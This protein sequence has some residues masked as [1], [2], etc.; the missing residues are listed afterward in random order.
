VLVLYTGSQHSLSHWDV[1]PKR[2]QIGSGMEPSNKR[3]L[4]WKKNA[5]CENVVTAYFDPNKHSQITVDASSSGLAAILAQTDDKSG[6]MRPIIYC[7]RS[8]SDVET[9]YSQTEL[10]ALSCVWAV[11]R[12]HQYVYGAPMFD[13]ITD[14]KAL[15]VIYGN[16]KAKLP[17]CIERWG[18]RLAPYQFRVI[19]KSGKDNPADYLS[20]HSLTSD[21]EN[22]RCEKIAEEYINLVINSAV[23]L[24]MTL[25]DIRSASKAD[26]TLTQLAKQIL[27]GK[28][29]CKNNEQLRPFKQV[30][31]ELSTS[32]GI[33][34]RQC[35]L[36]IPTVLQERAV[37]LAHEGHQGIVKTK[38]LLRTKCW[39][40]WI[41][42]MTEN[43]VKHCLACQANTPEKHFEQLLLLLLLLFIIVVV[44]YCDNQTIQFS[45]NINIINNMCPCDKLD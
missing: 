21:N 37:S 12:L 6:E 19:H 16:A 23:R 11:E 33:I 43:M 1:W 32:D 8:L 3:F 25:D 30:F 2:K 38:T 31:S 5:L 18:L 28:L 27:A 40:P 14:H 13:L 35:R 22:D 44:Y 20:R 24:A 26:P 4:T 9:R 10:E 42:E 15:E 34:L 7:S 45:T 39:F 41:D 29:D 36:V 17:A